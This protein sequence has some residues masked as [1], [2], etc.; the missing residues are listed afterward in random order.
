MPNFE[1]LQLERHGAIALLRLNL[2]HKLNAIALPLQQELR[3]ALA[4]L[5]DDASVHALVLTGAG[6]AFCAGA[7]LTGMVP[8][9]SGLSRGEQSFQTM[10]AL[11]NRIVQDL[12]E[13]PFPVIS[14]INGACAGGGVGIALGADIVLAAE[15][16]YF[17]LPFLPRL[18]IVPDLGSTW[19]LPRLIGRG[20][21][22][23][24]ALL[25][26]RLP[27]AQAQQWGLVWQV[28]ADAELEPT[29]LAMG[30][31]LAQLPAHAAQEVRRAY[32][33]GEQCGL[34]EQLHYEAQRQR[35]LIDKPSFQEG[36]Q[37]FLEKRTPVFQ[38]Q[39]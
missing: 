18:G 21:A 16:A 28:V 14:A 30:Q 23:A 27:A 20:R 3:Q 25:G 13:L 8:S 34:V 1:T 35:D 17:Y 2:P 32:S 4:M 9:D 15:S 29:A 31:R 12:H 7:D 38:R 11:T 36:V 10:E 6:K 26:D 33:H 19:F 22:T 24:L 37:A 39:G 5:R